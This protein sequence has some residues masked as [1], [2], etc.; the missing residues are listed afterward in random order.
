MEAFAEDFSVIVIHEAEAISVVGG[1]EVIPNAVGNVPFL[2][3]RDHVA[4]PA[5]A[6]FD[7]RVADRSEFAAPKDLVGMLL[8]KIFHGG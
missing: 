5:F 3:D 1:A 8:D 4:H 2:E 6:P 7:P